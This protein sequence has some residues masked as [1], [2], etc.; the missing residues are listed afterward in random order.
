LATSYARKNYQGGGVCIY[1]KPDIKFT[2][3][4]LTQY[5][6]DKNLEICALKIKVAKQNIIVICIYRSPHGNFEYFIKKLY[7]VLKILYKPKTEFV[8]C[9]DFNLNFLKQT[10]RK[11]KLLLL[12]Q[13]FNVSGPVPHNEEYQ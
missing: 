8:I 9:G 4:D 5:C 13:A 7:N 6:D 10:A 12:L 2:A 1:M 3:T 11:T